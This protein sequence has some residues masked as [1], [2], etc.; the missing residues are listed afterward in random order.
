MNSTPAGKSKADLERECRRPLDYASEGAYDH[1]EPPSFVPFLDSV[2][3]VWTNNEGI[4]VYVPY[5]YT[6]VGHQRL[7]FCVGAL[8]PNGY[9]VGF[10]PHIFKGAR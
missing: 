10:Q 4:T 3:D 2:K 9:S 7:A 6:Q 8:V 5:L 1:R